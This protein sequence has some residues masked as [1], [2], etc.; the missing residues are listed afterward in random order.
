MNLPGREDKSSR[1]LRQQAFPF[2]YSHLFLTNPF[3]VL[4]VFAFGGSQCEAPV[5][6]RR[7][8]SAY[9]TPEI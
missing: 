1:H 5:V 6:S 2:P 3:W 4:L 7:L 8:W 9:F